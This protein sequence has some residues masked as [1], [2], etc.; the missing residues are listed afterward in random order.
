VILGARSLVE[1][2]KLSDAEHELSVQAATIATDAAAAKHNLEVVVQ[3]L[4]DDKKAAAATVKELADRRAE[5]EQGLAERRQLLASVETEV[6]KLEAVERA[7]QEQLAAIAR[8]RLQAELEA[9]ARAQAQAAA[10]RRAALAAQQ[11]KAAAA[12]A[13]AASTT[14]TTTATTTTTTAGATTTTTPATATTVPTPTTTTTT[15]I[16]PPAPSTIPTPV[17]PVIGAQPTVP[18]GLLPPGHPEAAQIALSYLGVPY[19]WGGSTPSGFDCSG[20]VSYVYNQLGVLLPHFA[21]AQW[22]Y[23]VPVTIAQLQPGDL[24]FFDALDH[25]GIYLGNG[26]FV[27]APHTGAFVRIDSLQEKWYSK[28]YVGARRI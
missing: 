2:L 28:K 23:G 8:A 20:L 5:I 9:R 21:A 25:V 4:D 14:T 26:L 1:L 22:D 3:R 27:D 11:R 13:A 12:A 17:T 18:M 7:R 6:R 19:L 24:V 15:S 10:A 16:V